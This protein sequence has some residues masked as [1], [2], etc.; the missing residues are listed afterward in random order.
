MNKRCGRQCAKVNTG[1]DIP[2]PGVMGWK[3]VTSIQPLKEIARELCPCATLD[4]EVEPPYC[5]SVCDF[6]V[7]ETLYIKNTFKEST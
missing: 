3:Q 6:V 4:S 1:L 5:L 7:M 2:P